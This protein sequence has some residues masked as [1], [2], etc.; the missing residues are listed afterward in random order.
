MATTKKLTYFKARIEDKPGALSS[1][2]QDLKEK[3]LGLIGLKGVGQGGQGDVLVIPKFPEKMRIAWK[4]TGT[5]V[6]EGTLFFVSGTDTTGALVASLEAITQ[7]GVN[8]VAIEAAAVSGRFGAF[9]WVAPEDV[10]R[11]TQAL[12]AK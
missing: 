5:L 4:A 8:I 6:E 10:E 1:L 9:V 3:N 2:V 7:A 12:K 11:T